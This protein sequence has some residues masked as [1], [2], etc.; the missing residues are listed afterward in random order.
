MFNN[1]F[2][3][4]SMTNTAG[5]IADQG[6]RDAFFLRAEVLGQNKNPG[7]CH[8]R[9][10]RPRH[11]AQARRWKDLGDYGLPAPPFPLFRACFLTVRSPIHRM[12]LGDTRIGAGEM[13][14][15]PRERAPGKKWGDPGDGS[16]Q[17]VGGRGM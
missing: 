3:E 7:P 1:I 12:C 9:A 11:G 15:C 17:E 2:L 13:G 14:F 10:G 6:G 5:I 4:A 16:S 8:S